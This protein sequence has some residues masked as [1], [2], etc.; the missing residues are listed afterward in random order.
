[1]DS[2]FNV[3]RNKQQGCQRISGSSIAPERLSRYLKEEFNSHQ[4]E[5]ESRKNSYVIRAPRDLSPDEIQ[6][7]R[8][9]R[10]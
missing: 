9:S 6:R 5:F 2:S 1:M 3:R 4:F 7:L 8:T 10:M